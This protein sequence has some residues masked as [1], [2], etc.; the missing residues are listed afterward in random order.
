MP[1]PLAPAASRGWQHFL[2]IAWV[3]ANFCVTLGAGLSNDDFIW[4]AGAWRAL[5][6]SWLAAALWPHPWWSEHF[7][8]PLVQLTFFV[9]FQSAGLQPWVYHATNL[10][11]HMANV[12][13]LW[14][15]AR[16]RLSSPA[17]FLVAL[18]FSVHP[19]HAWSVG[20]VSGRTQLLCATF[21]LLAVHEHL[22]GHR[23]RATL[24][25]AAA[26]LSNEA[27]IIFPGLAWC[28][29]RCLDDRPVEA[30]SVISYAGIVAA[31][32][33]LRGVTTEPFGYGI[34]GIDPNALRD[35]ESIG[36]LW[37]D[38]IT[39]LGEYLFAPLPVHGFRRS[40]ILLALLAVSAVAAGRRRRV[41]AFAATWM[42]LA[43]LPYLGWYQL[44]PWYLY[45]PSA[46][47]SLWV[48]AVLTASRS[49]LTRRLL[50]LAAG[51]WLIAAVVRLA[52]LNDIQ[53]RAGDAHMRLLTALRAARPAP[54]AHTQFCLAGLEAL[55]LGLDAKA[56]APV[57]VFGLNE[58]VR[59]EYADTSLDVAF[60]DADGA[61]SRGAQGPLIHLTWEPAE[62]RFV[63][64]TAQ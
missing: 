64:A 43:L 55:R 52:Q 11:L 22:S 39:L 60:A 27:A 38:K 26:L 28:A 61:C 20:W 62:G 25:F 8:R 14:G 13:L 50:A 41:A 59:L 57:F 21:Q 44:Q 40:V 5:R 16:Q 32:L 2:L 1:A 49:P 6:S 31:Y 33:V 10:T 53:S 54:S 15:L 7:V 46:A 48:V 45:L 18:L 30:K 12:W 17:A 37:R 29:A 3:A 24:A 19:T 51:I 42:G 34:L 47:V 58:A 35:V 56:A 9:N 23:W 63:A 36:A 4:I